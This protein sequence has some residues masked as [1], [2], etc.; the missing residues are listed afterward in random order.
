MIETP[1]IRPNLVDA[2]YK[3]RE[4]AYDLRW[5]KK[6]AEWRFLCQ[7][8][9]RIVRSESSQEAGFHPEVRVIY[10]DRDVEEEM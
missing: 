8:P 7:K 4:I 1:Q 10:S 5:E 6:N 3:Q 2:L 9:P